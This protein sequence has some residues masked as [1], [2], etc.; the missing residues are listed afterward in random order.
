MAN[1]E[2]AF[3]IEETDPKTE[4]KVIYLYPMRKMR[5]NAFYG[6]TDGYRR[7]TKMRKVVVDIK[8]EG[9]TV[10]QSKGQ[11]VETESKAV[12]PKSQPLIDEEEN[13][14]RLEIMD[15]FAE[16]FKTTL[17]EVDASVDRIHLMEI[18]EYLA[19]LGYHKGQVQ[20]CLPEKQAALEMTNAIMDMVKNGDTRF[21]AHVRRFTFEDVKSLTSYL[22]KQGYTRK[23]EKV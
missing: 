1:K 4:K 6:P 15:D 11:P 17:K 8:D 2:I 13:R 7:V 21:L 9:D 14:N 3:G 18:A 16:G 12:M 19:R 5:D 22:A 20:D 10:E 23:Y